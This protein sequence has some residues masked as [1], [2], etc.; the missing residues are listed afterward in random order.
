MAKL[1]DTRN[2]SKTNGAL[3]LNAQ[4]LKNASKSLGTNALD[5]L[6]DISPNIY[7]VSESTARTANTVFKNITM[8]KTGQNK[9][10]NVL[11][12]NRYIKLAKTGLNNTLADLKSGNFNNESRTTDKDLGLDADKTKTYFD[13]MTDDESSDGGKT[14]VVNQVDNKGIAQVAANVNRQSEVTL[15]AANATINSIV[16]VS[17][18][19]MIQSQQIGNAIIGGLD[20]I[21]NSLQSII[22]YQN[23]NMTKFITASIG[24]YEKTGAAI[25]PDDSLSGKKKISSSDVVGKTFNASAYK[26]LVKQQ[27]KEY[28]D[29]SVPG[30][31]LSMINLYGDQLVANPLKTITTMAMKKIIPS[32]MKS[33]ITQVDKTVGDFM[34]TMLMRLYDEWGGSLDSGMRGT[35][36]R[37]LGKTF[38]LRIDRKERLNMSEKVTKE[39]ATFDKITRNAIVEELPKYARESTAYLKEIL[40]V[41]GGDPERALSTSQIFNRRTG[42][43][44][45]QKDFDKDTLQELTDSIVSAFNSSEFGKSMN[46][47]GSRLKERDQERYSKSLEKFYL[48]LEKNKKNNINI[49]DT[50]E[51]SDLYNIVNAIDADDSTKKFLLAAVGSSYRNQTGA[52]SLN[53]ARLQAKTQRNKFLKDIENS[54]EMYNGYAMGSVKSLDESMISVLYGN[55]KMMSS[56]DKAKG[57]LIDK[58]DNIEYLLK[59]GINVHVTGTTG[60]DEP[61]GSR[62]TSTGTN[63]TTQQRSASA[64]PADEDYGE[65]LDSLSDDKMNELLDEVNQQPMNNK[66]GGRASQFVQNKGKHLNNIMHYIAAGKTSMVY[67][68]VQEMFGD[69]LSDMGTTLKDKFLTP[70]KEKLLGD[71]DDEN[72]VLGGVKKFFNDVKTDTKRYIFGDEEKGEKGHGILGWASG[73][74]KKGIAGWNKTLFGADPEESSEEIKAK[75]A[76]KRKNTI[77]GGLAGAGVTTLT[78]GLLGNIIGGPVVGALLGSAVGLASDS[79]RFREYVFGKEEDDGNG[80]VT[81][82]GGV[83]SQKAQ[84]FLKKNKTAAVGGAVIGGIRGAFTGG[85]LLGTLV[86]G[87]IAGALM[88][89]AVGLVTS[90]DKFKNFIFGEEQ[91]DEQRIGGILNKFKSAM[92]GIGRDEK[93]DV[94]GGSV[95]AMGGVGAGTGLLLGMFTPLGPIGGAALGLASSM[96]AGKDKF[97]QFLFGSDEEGTD[98]QGLLGRFGNIMKADVFEP[99]KNVAKNAMEDMVEALKSHVLEPLEI[100]FEPVKIMGK[101]IYDAT[102]GKVKEK[103]EVIGDKI[104]EVMSNMANHISRIV[105][106]TITAPFKFIGRGISKLFSGATKAIGGVVNAVGDFSRRSNE[107]ASLKRMQEERKAGKHGNL[108]REWVNE[109]KAMDNP[110]M[111]LKE[112]ITDREKHRYYSSDSDDKRV[113]FRQARASRLSER[114]SR[115]EQQKQTE[116][117]NQLVSRLT[118]GKYS[119]LTEES[120]KEALDKYMNSKRYINGKGLNGFS[121]DEIIKLLGTSKDNAANATV[122]MEREQLDEQRKSS[123]FLAKIF[124]L[125]NTAVYGT[126]DGLSNLSGAIFNGGEA[127]DAKNLA[128]MEKEYGLPEGS[129]TGMAKGRRDVKR[130]GRELRDVKIDAADPA[131]R[132]AKEQEREF[133]ETFGNMSTDQEFLRRYGNDPDLDNYEYNKLRR[134]FRDRDAW[135]GERYYKSGMERLSDKLANSKAVGLLRTGRDKVRGF[136]EKI[137]VGWTNARRQGRDMANTYRLIRRKKAE[138]AAR[139]R[140]GGGVERHATGGDLR[141]G[142]DVNYTVVGENGPEVLEYSSNIKGHV[143]KNNDPI[144]V[145]IVEV[146]KAAAKEI[147]PD[148]QDVNL[149]GQDNPITT[150]GVGATL[151][152]N[153]DNKSKIIKAL[154]RPKTLVDINDI[155]D[156]FGDNDKKEEEK[157]ES[158]FDKIGGLIKSLGFGKLLGIGAAIAS[159]IALLKTKGAVIFEVLGKIKD[160]L[161]KFF[162]SGGEALLD[163]IQH[164][165]DNMKFGKESLEDGKTSAQMATD[166]MNELAALPEG[167]LETFLLGSDSKA[168]HETGARG[169]II[170]KGANRLFG[171]NAGVGKIVRNTRSISRAFKNAPAAV[172]RFTKGVKTKASAVK[173]FGVNAVKKVKG[174]G[175]KFARKG[176]D[177]ASTAA[178]VAATEPTMADFMARYA[179]NPDI[180][181]FD[182]NQLKKRF[183]SGDSSF[184]TEGVDEIAGGVAKNVDNVAATVVKSSADDIAEAAGK[185]VAKNADD[186]AK[187]GIKTVGSSGKLKNLVTKGAKKVGGTAKKAA[188]AVK[189]VA[190]N[191]KILGKIKDMFGKAAKIMGEK[192]ASMKG[193]KFGKLVSPLSEF[194]G[195]I[196]KTL[197]VKSGKGASI[198]SKGLAKIGTFLAGTG[199]LVATGV[200]ALAVLGSNVVQCTIGGVM[201]ATKAGVA[202]LFRCDESVVDGKMRVISAVIGALLGT[203]PGSIVDMVNEIITAI[204]G[205]DLISELATVIYSWWCKFEGNDKDYDE[206]VASQ[207]EQKKEYAEYKEGEIEAQ[208]QEYLADNGL[209]SDEFSREEFNKMIEE[210]QISVDYDSYA[211]YNDKQHQ[212][213]GD[214]IGNAVATGAGKVWSGVKKGVSA[215]GSGIKKGV[216]AIGSGVK[217]G[218]SAAKEGISNAASA[219]GGALKKTF[220]AG[221]S[222]TKVTLKFMKETESYMKGKTDNISAE[223]LKDVPFGNAITGMTQALLSPLNF[224]NGLI[225]KLGDKVK[226]MAGDALDTVKGLFGKLFGTDGKDSKETKAGGKGG[227]PQY[228]QKDP[229]WS[230]VPYEEGGRG[231]ET[232][233]R[234]GC[235][236]TAFA[237]AASA[238][239]NKK[240]SPVASANVMKAVG[241][242]DNTGTNWSGINRAASV[243]GIPSTMSRNP[244][245][246]FVD[247]SLRQGKPVILSGKSS[248]GRGN[249]PYTKGGHYVVATGMDSR[250]NYKVN[251]PNS[252]VPNKTYRKSDML[253]QTGAA[254][255]FGGRGYV[256]TDAAKGMGVSSTTNITSK[257]TTKY[258]TNLVA[259]SGIPS[260]VWDR[261]SPAEK[262]RYSNTA[263]STNRSGSSNGTGITAEDVI[264][265]ATNEIG[266]AETGE[267]ITKY[268]E[269]MGQNGAPWC[270]SFVMWCM[271]QAANQN[272][273]AVKQIING[274][275]TAK[276]SV[277]QSQL[278]PVQ[279]PQPG[280]MIFFNYN[281]KGTSHVGIVTG[282]EGTKVKTVEGNTGG[283]TGVNGNGGEVKAKSYDISNSKITGFGRPNYDGTSTWNGTTDGGS[284]MLGDGSATA[285][286]TGSKALGILG[287]F[288]SWMGEVAS[289]AITG[290]STGEFNNDWSGWLSEMKGGASYSAATGTSATDASV[291]DVAGYTYSSAGLTGSDNAQ[292]IWNFLRSK[293]YSEAATAGIMGNLQQESSLNPQ[294][295]QKGGLGRGLCQWSEG[296]RWE[297]L[298]AFAAQHGLDP[299]SLEAQLEFLDYELNGGEA[300]TA[301]K[302]KSL[303]GGLDGLKNA[304]EVTTAA[305]L[306]EKSFERAGKPM[307]EKRYNYANDFYNLYKGSQATASSTTGSPAVGAPSPRATASPNVTMSDLTGLRTGPGGFGDE[308]SLDDS[309]YGMPQ[310]DSYIETNGGGFGPEAISAVPGTGAVDAS[311]TTQTTSKTYSVKPLPSNPTQNDY[312]KQCVTYLG[313]IL[314]VLG[315]SNGKLDKLDKIG[316]SQGVAGVNVNNVTNNNMTNNSSVQA[317][318]TTDTKFATA[319]QIAQGGL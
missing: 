298:K 9:I 130:L 155:D 182:F 269:M 222:F 115:R 179:D 204:A 77:L 135:D 47:A 242:R 10:T 25:A 263:T 87:P 7:D 133:K 3:K 48:A 37:S 221:V 173:Q 54:P 198:I 220:T 97:K 56:R 94:S 225:G 146:T 190:G 59:R 95:A 4:W 78:G 309:P 164:L 289:R 151:D 205:Y 104:H 226:D 235:G 28:L 137:S 63:A 212:T 283:S 157:Q 27:M 126:K 169:K 98:E 270:C 171:K 282:M 170:L 294:A 123:G 31:M 180:D 113:Q 194:F 310:T 152:N 136:G 305:D 207:E 195:K 201:G 306:F 71:K 86:G 302:L 64:T 107:K 184:M 274:N 73:T 276:C 30:Q 161:G 160:F 216:K 287:M 119:E 313:H 256:P 42:K 125:L 215:V 290:I 29:E 234:A 22:A 285:S 254:W 295:S 41:L 233:G 317:P 111:T 240:I 81:H 246:G 33:T 159:L 120:R 281:G 301:S 128:K 193:S 262:M 209:D 150:Y 156:D 20:N 92:H 12:Q 153:T 131:S 55:S 196:I 273:D 50:S 23:E 311:A 140:N 199:S 213:V 186:V 88:G 237:M 280:D 272:K 83:I 275:L 318:K 93:G 36:K 24:Y 202:K 267:N 148:V 255:S 181:Q 85:G 82:V 312:L 79:K 105:T 40:S 185:T 154:Q 21:N 39:A 166:E 203:T 188:T 214:K 6:K 65:S 114:A 76:K 61:S 244:S 101:R 118:G 192:M 89:T 2:A 51:G 91:E 219:V 49:G 141:G 43:Y 84:D 266:Y 245:E 300:T 175:S 13:A 8:S 228:S 168:D 58:I 16:A 75:I 46:L 210:G 177:V 277:L 19:S 68:E 17:S 70:M 149:I 116:K 32:V 142:N 249:T 229:R 304:T 174:F 218:V 99:V 200:G 303:C 253:N 60:F 127:K 67:S 96:I 314:D 315:D 44:Q 109:Y 124:G 11:S 252:N 197:S 110:Q 38:G 230:D 191:S 90:S 299:W 57:A 279:T 1:K 163:G 316:G 264:K 183:L 147:K 189:E 138:E 178:S 257:N 258:A 122:E 72:S 167:D 121:S 102:L 288:G 14:L 236:P 162:K 291:S 271:V 69:G 238:A 241:A 187:T 243:Y 145:K 319:T 224:F 112:F 139:L 265:I 227:V 132:R 108:Y 292:K 74:L 176:A 293:G 231:P 144:S 172:G 158:I 206:L 251:D 26:D 53:S 278:E 15:K 52:M 296:G 62:G 117:G 18:A 143:T 308:I 100:A 250:G 239:T 35:I 307:M 66:S 129:L 217:K 268:G 45:E 248:G 103:F 34:P 211:D 260:N 208:Y 286:G 247:S 259:P 5:V 106:A 165:S 232:M 80:G 261:L 284:S 223:V 134:Q 297:T